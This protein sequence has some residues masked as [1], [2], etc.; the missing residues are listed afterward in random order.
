M[1]L[2]GRESDGGYRLTDSRSH[3]SAEFLASG[4]TGSSCPMPGGRPQHILPAIPVIESGR[5]FPV[6]TLMHF[7]GKAHALLD[8]ASGRY[9]VRLLKTL[10]GVSR[11]WLKR[12]DNAHLNEIDTIAEILGRP[13]VYFFSVNY[14]WGCTCQAGPAPDG[15]SARL[16]RV[17][18]WAADGLG[19]HLVGV[20]VSGASAGPLVL[21]TWPGYSGVLQVMAP[22]RFSAAINQAPMRK[23]V[24]AFYLDWVSGR[25]RVWSMP[26]PT[27]AHVLR[28]VA[29]RAKTYA[30][31]RRLLIERPLSTPAIFTLAG[32]APGE[33][34]VIERTE[35]DARV[36]DGLQVAANHWETA[37]WHGHPRGE[38]SALR[39]RMM[40]AIRPDFD[41]AMAWLKAP[42]FNKNTRLSMV[43]DARLGRLMARGFEK[44]APATEVLDLSWP[45]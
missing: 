41:P 14:E 29:E 9:P 12:W 7:K 2:E 22:G 27:P 34:S 10:D 39:S 11:A 36:R 40:T 16:I 3:A 45:M 28:E 43:A 24:G 20:R 42:I 44:S 6:E 38:Q 33:T 30:E 8:A 4:M 1:R 35:R 26:F 37:G 5:D 13:G 23:S 21:V 15:L 17:L 18:D 32:L 25:R 31:A 19:R